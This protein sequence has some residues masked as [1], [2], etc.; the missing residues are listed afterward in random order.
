M[1]REQAKQLLI[2]YRPG[3]AD[4]GDPEITQAMAWVQNDPELG[5]WF[6]EHCA[7]QTAVRDKVRQI[8]VYA[9]LKEQIISEQAA[10]Q[11]NASRRD[12][13]KAVAAVA[14]IILSALIITTMYLPHHQTARP[15]PP[16]PNTLATF[17]SQMMAAAISGYS[18]YAATNSEQVQSY[19]ARNQAP[20]E[21]NLPAGLQKIAISGCAIE[22]WQ[23]GRASMIC[24][25]TRPLPQGQ[26]SDMWLF[27]IDRSDVTDVS[28]IAPP[29]LAPL[30]GLITATWTQGDKLYLLG[31]KGDE[32]TIRQYL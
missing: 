21:Y 2:L 18:I 25:K 15:G 1:N 14:A 11:R 19:L 24:F 27:V 9:G 4:D 10:K 16:V 22:F 3:S 12:R 5:K 23:K 6:D 28:T 17:Q 13:L 26:M 29:Q 8:P 31:T 30:N 7:R 20:A 32:Q